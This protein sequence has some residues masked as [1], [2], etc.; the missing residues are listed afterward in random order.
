MG[1]LGA[2]TRAVWDPD[3]LVC[4][5]PRKEAPAPAGR[6]RERAEMEGPLRAASKGLPGP[7]LTREKGR[8][9]HP[10]RNT[11]VPSRLCPSRARFKS[12]FTRS[13]ITHHAQ[14]LAGTICSNLTRH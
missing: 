9:L 1:Q 11:P 12:R 7:V 14:Y 4:R 5:S 3:G 10:R 2:E 6:G 13:H 8:I